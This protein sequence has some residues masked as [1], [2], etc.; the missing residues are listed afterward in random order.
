[1]D[2]HHGDDHAAC[3]VA[4][5]VAAVQAELGII[6]IV[7]EYDVRVGGDEARSHIQ[8]VHEV[9]LNIHARPDLLGEV[10]DVVRNGSSVCRAFRVLVAPA[11]IANPMST[12]RGKRGDVSARAQ[13]WLDVS[14][15]ATRRA[16]RRRGAA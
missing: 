15:L 9:R 12:L 13:R 10:N 6:P 1:M 7:V 11:G 5:I 3:W 16:N 14:D 4:D 8:A 2:G